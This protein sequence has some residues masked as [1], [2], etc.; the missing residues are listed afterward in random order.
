M[1]PRSE[2]DLVSV[3]ISDTG[4]STLIEEEAFDAGPTPL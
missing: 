4:D 2:Q 1:D 3:D